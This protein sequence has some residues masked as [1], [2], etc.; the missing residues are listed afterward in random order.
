LEASLWGFHC[1]DSFQNAVLRVVNL[2]DDAD[3]TS[4]VC[5][6]LAGAYWGECGISE[7]WLTKLT[8]REMIEQAIIQITQ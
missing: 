4:A 2:D 5:G 3:K 7:K 8:K 1:S 6:Q